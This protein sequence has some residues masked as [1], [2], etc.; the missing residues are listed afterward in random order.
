MRNLTAAAVFGRWLQYCEFER[1]AKLVIG[2]V[3]ARMSRRSL[4]AAT[5]TWKARAA[6]YRRQR[7]LAQKVLGRMA[8]RLQ[9]RAFGSWLQAVAARRKVQEVLAAATRSIARKKLGAVLRAWTAWVADRHLRDALPLRQHCD[10]GARAAP[11][12]KQGGAT[13]HRRRRACPRSRIDGSCIP[14]R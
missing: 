1:H 4:F 14:R 2:R 8:Q 12:R 13:R 3:L 6:E 5:R 11:V 9:A 10:P 7:G